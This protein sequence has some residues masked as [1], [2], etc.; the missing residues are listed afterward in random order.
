MVHQFDRAQKL[1]D[2]YPNMIHFQSVHDQNNRKTYVRTSP[3]F[4]LFGQTWD[5]ATV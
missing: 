4:R 2:I 5:K 3:P 1:L